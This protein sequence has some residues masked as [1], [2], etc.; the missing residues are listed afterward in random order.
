LRGTGTVVNCIVENN[1]S[2]SPWEPYGG[3]IQIGYTDRVLGTV[4]NCLIRYNST[5]SGGGLFLGSG[6]SNDVLIA[7]CTVV[8]NAGGGI[9]AQSANM[10]T[11][12]LIFNCVVV[13]NTGD[14]IYGG[15]TNFVVYS[16]STW[17]SNQWSVAFIL[18]N[19]NTTNDPKFTS[20][21]DGNYRFNR[22]SP[23]FNSGTNQMGWMNGAVDLD[24]HARIL[25]SRVDMGAY[26]L[27]I[28]EGTMFRGR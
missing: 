7:N 24:G 28:P 18:I 27:L 10:P 5:T 11:N 22:Y 1:R 4:K 20:F 23:C 13:S 2:I 9:R 26:E 16:C 17:Q 21:T 25:H 19:G 12:A 8:S 6:C 15:G 3:G 14:N